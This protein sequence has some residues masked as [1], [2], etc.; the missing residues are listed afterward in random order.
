[1]TRTLTAEQEQAAQRLT[2]TQ[3][4]ALEELLHS[5]TVWQADLTSSSR[6][7]KRTLDALVSA[8]FATWGKNP[9][10]AP[11]IKFRTASA[12]QRGRRPGRLRPVRWHR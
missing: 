1:M 6:W 7:S 2:S 11:H 9:A 12:G 10:A 4:R 3:R 8:G 5:G